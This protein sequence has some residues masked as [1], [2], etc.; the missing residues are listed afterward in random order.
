LLVRAS[1]EVSGGLLA[2]IVSAADVA[3]FSVT[4]AEEEPAANQGGGR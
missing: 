3:G 4:W 1:A 2:K